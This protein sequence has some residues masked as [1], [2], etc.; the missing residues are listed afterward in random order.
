MR[1][2]PAELSIQP[3]KSNYSNQRYK[4][5]RPVYHR[6]TRLAVCYPDFSIFQNGEKK[7]EIFFRFC[8][9]TIFLFRNFWIFFIFL[10]FFVAK[11]IFKVYVPPLFLIFTRIQMEVCREQHRSW[12]EM[13]GVERDLISFHFISCF[14]VSSWIGID[15]NEMNREWMMPQKGRPTVHFSNNN[16]GTPAVP[17][18]IIQFYLSSS[19]LPRLRLARGLV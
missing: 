8:F 18:Q 15:D 17:F 19:C 3:P 10:A 1:D 11:K 6:N 4:Y 14:P 16:W 7:S 13:S 12:A 9:L 2:A 5:D